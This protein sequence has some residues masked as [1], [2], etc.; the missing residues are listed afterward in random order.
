MKHDFT[1]TIKEVLKKY[2]RD[3]YEQIFKN[4]ELLQYLNIKTVSANRG[5]KSRG[6][7]ANIYAIQA[8][9]SGI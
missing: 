8:K 5:S 2:F 7:F 6:S 4:S 9:Q 3:D 1:D